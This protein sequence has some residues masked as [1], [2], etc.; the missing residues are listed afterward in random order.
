MSCFLGLASQPFH[1][2]VELVRERSKPIPLILAEPRDQL[3]P[4]D[5]RSEVRL[6]AAKY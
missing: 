5:V 2:D 6:C 1:E 3:D 4:S